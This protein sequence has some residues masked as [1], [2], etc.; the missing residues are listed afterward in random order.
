MNS[1]FPKVVMEEMH[2]V[3][4][5]IKKTLS[6]L[7]GLVCVWGRYFLCYCKVL[8]RI[9]VTE[10]FQLKDLAADLFCFVQKTFSSFL[11]ILLTKLNRARPSE[12]ISKSI[13]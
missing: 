5:E 2:P 10:V 3:E 13:P 4:A 1:Q 9:L 12:N 7:T 6:D 11:A 8:G